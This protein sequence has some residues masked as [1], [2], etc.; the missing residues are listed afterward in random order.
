MSRVHRKD[1]NVA[2]KQMK[3]CSTSLNTV[4]VSTKVTLE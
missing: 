2:L 1:V 4:E 3:I